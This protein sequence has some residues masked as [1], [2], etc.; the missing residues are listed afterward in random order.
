[1]SNSYPSWRFHPSGASCIVSGKV[2]DSHLSADWAHSPHDGW[3]CPSEA[4]FHGTGALPDHLRAGYVDGVE[5]DPTSGYVDESASVTLDVSEQT[6]KTVDVNKS[7]KLSLK[8][9]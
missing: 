1:M 5:N 7:K 9:K 6:T 4:H 8:R 2:E 3:I